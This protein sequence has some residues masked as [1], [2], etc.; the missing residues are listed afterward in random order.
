[1]VTENCKICYSK[2]GSQALNCPNC[3][4]RHREASRS[5]FGNIIWYG[6]IGYNF[7]MLI[8]FVLEFDEFTQMINSIVG[9]THPDGTVI[10]IGL[11]EI[12]MLF[13]CIMGDLVLGMMTL[14]TRPER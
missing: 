1:M 14:L 3:G 11:G 8:L 2:I 9:K 7:L 10:T 12:M 4:I 5:A 13:I 6:F